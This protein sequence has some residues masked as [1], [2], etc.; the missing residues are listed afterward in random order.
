MQRLLLLG[1]NH[2][3]APLAVRERIALDAGGCRAATAAFRARFPEA[4][5]VVLS[6]CNRVEL[7]TARAV[8]GH[9][10]SEEMVEFLAQQQG[11]EAESLRSHLY[12]KTDREV[13]DHLFRVAASL[14]SMVLGETQ[15]LGQVRQAYE[16]AQAAGGVGAV[17]NPLFQRAVGVGK[18]VMTQTAIGEGRLSVAS[19]AVDYA[20]RIFERFDDKAVL[21]IGAGKMG[22]LVLQHLAGL[23]PRRLEVCSRDLAKAQRVAERFGGSGIPFDEVEAALVRADIVVTST[24]ATQPIITRRQ[25]EAIRRA[26]RYRRIFII[27]IAM[28]RDVEAEVGG[29]DQVYLYNLDDLQQA[30]AGTQDSRRQAVSE[31]E[32]V[33]SSAVEEFIAWNRSRELGPMIERLYQRSHR[34]AQEE[35]ARTLGKR[36]DATPADRAQ[37]EELARRIVNK[38]LHHPVQQLRQ[39]DSLHLPGA[40]YLHAVE[41]LF[42]LELER[43]VEQ[44]SEDRKDSQT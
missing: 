3:T 27:D 9:P 32:Q 12:E 14:N 15:I 30:V 26:R 37:L 10:R 44:R 8:H 4:E 19:V 39:G 41:K 25:F 35:V 13:V 24:G 36:P 20:R 23:S 40:P 38:L 5:L 18:A 31:A 16:A 11:V 34:I 21:A 42:R 7:Y 28:P 1:L 22:V 43:E 33:V 17:L 29:L 6:T 2:A